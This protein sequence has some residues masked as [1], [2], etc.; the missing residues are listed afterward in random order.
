[1]VLTGNKLSGG[2]EQPEQIKAS[3][4]FS[5]LGKVDSL[6]GTE[7]RRFNEAT[8]TNEPKQAPFAKPVPMTYYSFER[9]MACRNANVAT[10][11]NLGG[12]DG[13]QFA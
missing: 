13:Q 2:S 9:T 11:I 8:G 1:M 12:E 3:G 7:E 6:H 10:V 4:L 5:K